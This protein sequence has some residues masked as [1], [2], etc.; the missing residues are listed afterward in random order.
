[1]GVFAIRYLG[2]DEKLF[3]KENTALGPNTLVYDT[4]AKVSGLRGD[5][6]KWWENIPMDPRIASIFK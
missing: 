2:L 5:Y 4:L 3:R 1:V 6:E